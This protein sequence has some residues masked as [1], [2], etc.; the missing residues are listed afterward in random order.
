MTTE[1]PDRF[2]AM[3]EMEIVALALA[4]E[5][6]TEMKRRRKTKKLTI[7][8]TEER[9]NAGDSRYISSDQYDGVFIIRCD[10][11]LA[12]FKTNIDF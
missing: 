5:T 10:W 4:K 12:I 9:K 11:W 3:G 6:K 2:R 8:V 1:S 7:M